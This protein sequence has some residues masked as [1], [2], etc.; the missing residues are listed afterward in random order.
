[1][2]P[3]VNIINTIIRR[4]VKKVII[5]QRVGIYT[6]LEQVIDMIFKELADQRVIISAEHRQYIKDEVQK[7]LQHKIR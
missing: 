1:M 7:R 2:K 5:A 4:T 6:T 3:S